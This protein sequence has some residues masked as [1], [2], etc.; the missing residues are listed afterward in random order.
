MTVPAGETTK[1]RY[2]WKGKPKKHPRNGDVIKTR[3]GRRYV[4]LCARGRRIE[5]GTEMSGA[6]YGMYGDVTEALGPVL[7]IAATDPVATEAGPTSGTFTIAR[8]STDGALT[9]RYAVGGTAGS[10]VDYAALATSVVIAHGQISATLTVAPV[11]DSDGEGRGEIVLVVKNLDMERHG[12]G[13]A[14]NVA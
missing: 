6:K 12:V 3:T 2:T 14:S 4:I 9:V 8:T 13:L 7:S 11:D 1:I 5:G 10:G